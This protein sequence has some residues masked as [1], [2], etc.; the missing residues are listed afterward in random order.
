MSYDVIQVSPST[1][2]IG[3]EVSGVDLTQPLSNRAVEEVHQALVDSGV[4]FFRDQP[5]EP[6]S[7]RRL[8]AYFG[9]LHTHPLKGMEGFPEIRTI[10]ADEN[11]KH[12]AGEEWHT[13]LS[14]DPT[15]RRWAAS[16]A[17]RPCRLPEATP[18]SPACT[19]PTTRCQ[20]G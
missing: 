10:Y 16:S 15:R 1:P 18:C 8:G 14:C 11:S 17:S 20:I 3:A 6:A 2:H 7:L 19:Q 13:D 5:L 9:N 4:I 12:V